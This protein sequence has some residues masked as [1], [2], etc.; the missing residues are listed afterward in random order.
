MGVGKVVDKD[1]V[2]PSDREVYWVELNGS[3]VSKVDLKRSSEVA[4]EP[5]SRRVRR[6]NFGERHKV[7]SARLNPDTDGM[8][9]SGIQIYRL[10]FR[11][12]KLALELEELGVTTLVTKQGARYTR[13]G[14]GAGSAKFKRKD[15]VSFKLSKEKY[16]GWDLDQ[17]L[18]QVFDRWWTTHS[19]LFEGHEPK[20]IESAGSFDPSFLHIRIDRNSTLEDV[21]HFITT[22]VQ[23]Q[24]TGTPLYS[25]DGY[26]RPDVV[27]NRYNALILTL[28]GWE[29]KDICEG[30]GKKAI[31]L[32]STDVRSKDDRLAVGK[33]NKTGKL[34]W[35]STVSKQRNGGLWHLQDVL[36]GKFGDVPDKGVR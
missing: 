3:P 6:P 8:S 12:L 23:P 19:Y 9:A 7:R 10:W 11:F 4:L 14:G 31:Y 21:R 13:E 22:E 27:Q 1:K 33:N 20:F 28:K 17:V 36:V 24:L 2:K 30:G 34:L 15:T 16:D 29:A 26:P 18:T 25:V 32:R 5:H 35:S